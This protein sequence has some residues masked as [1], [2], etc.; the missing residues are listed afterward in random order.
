MTRTNLPYH[1]R[2]SS[3]FLHGLLPS[4]PL[5]NILDIQSAFPDSL[6]LLFFF[7]W[8][9]ADVQYYVSFRCT[10]KWFLIF[11]SYVPFI[12]IV[13]YWLCLHLLEPSWHWLLLS[14]GSLLRPT[15]P[16]H[17]S[18]TPLNPYPSLDSPLRNPLV[19]RP[20]LKLYCFTQLKWT[21]H[22]QYTQD[23]FSISA[24]V[25]ECPHPSVLSVF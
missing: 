15:C 19:Q 16:P 20:R 2:V 23:I 8:G 1:A 10:T 18:S 24:L 11:K 25:T 17:P 6:Y 21:I 9:I 12:V 14:A 7:N 22:G 3:P 5:S 13:K 4:L